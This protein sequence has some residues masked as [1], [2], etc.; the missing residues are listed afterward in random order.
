MNKVILMCGIPGAGKSTYAKSISEKTGAKRFS[1]D[2]YREL[3]YI[4]PDN[5]TPEEQALIFN[6]LYKD[7]NNA[8]A[9]GQDII[10]DNT[11]VTSKDRQ[12]TLMSLKGYTDVEIIIVARPYNKCLEANIMRNRVVPKEALERMYKRFQMPAKG[13]N[14]KISN[15]SIVYTRE[16]EK[17]YLGHYM[18][19]YKSVIDYDQKNHHHQ[20]TLGEHLY[21][22]G[23]YIIENIGN[24]DILVKAAYL[25]VSHKLQSNYDITESSVLQNKTDDK[26]CGKPFC[27]T[28][29]ENSEHELCF[30]N[31]NNVSA[32]D[33]MFYD[34]LTDDEKLNVGVLITYHDIY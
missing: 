10:I 33:C 30:H 26:D 23:Q 6:T 15:I 18:D 8:L 32:Y 24:D 25:H 14:D 17:T 16:E 1:A 4:D 28:L 20:F 7:A 34:G 27:A 31:H 5:A 21:K 11:N 19:Y 9:H 13:E 29:K 22:T 3:F 2:D 12:R